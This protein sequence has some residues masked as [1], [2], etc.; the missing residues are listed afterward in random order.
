VIVVDPAVWP[1]RGQR[2]AHLAS[3]RDLAELHAFAVRLGLRRLAFQGDHYDVDEAGRLRALGAGAEA[4]SARELVRRLR[5]AGLRRNG[6]RA[7]LRWRTVGEWP[8]TSLAVTEPAAGPSAVLPPGAPLADL[9]PAGAVAELVG[10]GRAL[11]D[12]DVVLRLLAR[13]GEAAA[14]L[15]RRGCERPLVGF[16]VVVELGSEPP[17]GSPA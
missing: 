8:L 17:A 13:R 7:V 16:E 11:A 15:A 10:R 3:D 9:L 6:P 12:D 2:W 5:G 14:V 1:W 4:V